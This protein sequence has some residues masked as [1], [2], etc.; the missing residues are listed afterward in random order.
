MPKN[1]LIYV[2]VLFIA[3]CA[4]LF[5]AFKFTQFVQ[6]ILPYALG[7]GILMVVAGIFWEA[8]KGKAEALKPGAQ[9]A[10]SIR[11]TKL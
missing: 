7:L 9:T 3:A 8:R 10:E 2:G 6:P 11:E 5:L 4:L 1:R